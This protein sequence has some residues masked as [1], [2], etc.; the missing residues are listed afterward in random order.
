MLNKK[1]SCYQNKIKKEEEKKDVYLTMLSI[2]IDWDSG[3]IWHVPCLTD[4]DFFNM[5]EAYVSDSFTLPLY[6]DHECSFYF[7]STYTCK[8]K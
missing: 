6:K 5:F 8:K 4:S 2:S 1:V 7:S 3:R